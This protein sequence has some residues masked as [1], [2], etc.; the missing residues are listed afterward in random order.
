MLR[1]ALNN[2]HFT[3]QVDDEEAR[4][5][6]R[7]GRGRVLRRMHSVNSRVKVSMAGG[8]YA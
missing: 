4:R 3:R 7:G 6:L 8:S 1:N 5:F 2:R